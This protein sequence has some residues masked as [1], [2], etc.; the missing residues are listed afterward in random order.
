MHR[1]WS[2]TTTI[3]LAS[4]DAEV[5]L[6]CSGWSALSAKRDANDR[7]HFEGVPTSVRQAQYGENRRLSCAGLKVSPRQYGVHRYALPS[8]LA[9]PQPADGLFRY[10]RFAPALA[11]LSLSSTK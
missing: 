9:P 6:A 1:L 11:T 8:A 7:G 4:G 3:R 2:S 10:R 5:R